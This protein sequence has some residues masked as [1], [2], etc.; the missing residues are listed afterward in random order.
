[1][2][3]VHSGLQDVVELFSI[4]RRGSEIGGVVCWSGENLGRERH[5]SVIT[6]YKVPKSRE[7]TKSL[8]YEKF[9]KKIK[10]NHGCRV[11]CARPEF[12]A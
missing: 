2:C 3:R 6:K 7:S 9:S 4:F 8:N 1:M 5:R 10:K 12:W 11:R